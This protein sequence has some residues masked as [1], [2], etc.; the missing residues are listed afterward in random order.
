MGYCPYS[1]FLLYS[2]PIQ[3]YD[4]NKDVDEMT[5]RSVSKQF[6]YV[7]IPTIPIKV[8]Y[9][10]GMK[11]QMIK[12]KEEILNLPNIEYHNKLW[13][14]IDLCMAI[15]KDCTR[16]L[17]WQIT[18]EKV[19]ISNRL[20]NLEIPFPL[21]ESGSN[22]PDKVDDKVVEAMKAKL[23]MGDPESL[24]GVKKKGGLANFLTRKRSS[25]KGHKLLPAS[26]PTLPVEGISL[27][28]DGLGDSCV[29]PGEWQEADS[30]GEK[31]A[32]LTAISQEGVDQLG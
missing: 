16:T 32:E 28:V 9:K 31:I 5:A 29:V 3:G 19:G 17:V 25:K 8:S 20:A 14:W 30:L 7:K 27:P 24:E 1:L 4:P 22:R 13:T 2:I 15:K 12:L 18:K 26:F 23:L 10:G 21:S 6:V 11:G